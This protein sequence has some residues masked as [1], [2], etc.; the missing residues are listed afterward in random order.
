MNSVSMQNNEEILDQ[1]HHPAF[2]QNLRQ[3]MLKFAVLQLS[4]LSQV[5]NLIQEALVSAFKHLDG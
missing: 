5:E 2:L 3:Q 4:S 1:L